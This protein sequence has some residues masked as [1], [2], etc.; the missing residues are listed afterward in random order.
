MSSSVSLPARCFCLRYVVRVPFAHCYYFLWNGIPA[1][2]TTTA[3]TI[4]TATVAANAIAAATA[5][6]IFNIITFTTIITYSLLNM[7]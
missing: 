7:H 4:A 3:V 5:I 2:L 6:T 1:D